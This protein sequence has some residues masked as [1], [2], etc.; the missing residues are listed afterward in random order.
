M[1]L[2]IVLI[3]LFVQAA[4]AQVSADSLAKQLPDSSS[5]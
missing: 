2:P 4:F 5:K 3:F 1:K